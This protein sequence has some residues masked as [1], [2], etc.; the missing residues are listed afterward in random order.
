MSTGRWLLASLQRY[1]LT[2]LIGWTAAV[3]VSPG[4]SFGEEFGL[5]MRLGLVAVPLL[6][7]GTMFVVILLAG[8]RF[9][10]P[11]GG[12]QRIRG[13]WMVVLPLAPLLPVGLLMP[14]QYVIMVVT[15]LVFVC[16]VLPC[17]DARDTAGVLR[18]LA[19]PDVPAEQR[20]RIARAVGE[21][22]SRPVQEALVKAATDEAPEVA[23]AA[24]HTLC[25][26]WRRNDA[27]G[28]DLLMK[29]HPHGQE[30]VRALG[31]KVRSPW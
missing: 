8:R 7:I 28:E 16:W 31:V 13:G 10:P 1:V 21:L 24:L 17:Q 9:E 15:Q 14:L 19:D 11:T 4:D 5:G 23:E 30:Q 18:L 22:H 3:A 20:A 2:A 26:I 6:T 29:L 12:P 25:T 27:I